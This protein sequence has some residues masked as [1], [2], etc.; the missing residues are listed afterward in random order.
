[1]TEAEE[2]LSVEDVLASKTKAKAKAIDTS[3]KNAQ[4]S[5]TTYRKAQEII[6]QNPSEELLNRLRGGKIK[7]DKA[8]RKIKNL[9]KRQVL[10]SNG[11]ISNVLFPD[12][13]HLNTTKT[14]E[15]FISL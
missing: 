7:I 11:A 2:S 4:V 12:N 8:Y 14:G 9:Q 1:M 3:A 15:N 5:T 6:N 10:L 13:I